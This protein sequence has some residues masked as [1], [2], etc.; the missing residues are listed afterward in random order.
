MIQ[1]FPLKITEKGVEVEAPAAVVCENRPRDHDHNG[2][3][4]RQEAAVRGSW[5][6]AS[7]MQERF[8]EE[9]TQSAVERAVNTLRIS[10]PTVLCQD[11][12]THF[13]C[14]TTDVYNDWLLNSRLGLV[15]QMGTNPA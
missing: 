8:L 9:S 6:Q 10:R 14:V 11:F 3:Q 1:G 4:R 15:R 2:M 7:R 5:M 12:T 13:H